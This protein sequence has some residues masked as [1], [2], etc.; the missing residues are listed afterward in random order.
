MLGGDGS[1]QRRVLVYDLGAVT[2]MAT[3]ASAGGAGSPFGPPFGC[4]PLPSSTCTPDEG[5]GSACF[6]PASV[7]LLASDGEGCRGCASAGRAA[8]AFA[9]S[10]CCQGPASL[11]VQLPGHLHDP[12][13]AAGSSDGSMYCRRVAA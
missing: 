2:S 3:G 13:R 4:R 1:D 8:V 9:F 7:S 10:A 6:V 5:C 11:R 12:P